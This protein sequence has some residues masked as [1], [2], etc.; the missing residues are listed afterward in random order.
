MFIV[1]YYRRDKFLGEE[2]FTNL[3][4]AEDS[5][6]QSKYSSRA[7]Y[8]EIIDSASDAIIQEFVIPTLG[9]SHQEGSYQQGSGLDWLD[10]PDEDL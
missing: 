3:E 9:L 10:W 6:Y 5:L 4:K 8:Y 1:K 7:D 2:N